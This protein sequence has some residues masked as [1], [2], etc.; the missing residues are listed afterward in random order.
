MGRVQT[1]VKK[2]RVDTSRKHT[3]GRSSSVLHPLTAEHLSTSSDS[4]PQREL[5]PAQP[6]TT[7]TPKTGHSSAKFA[8]LHAL[9]TG[10]ARCG[11]CEWRL[12]H[13]G[14]CPGEIV[15]AEQVHWHAGTTYS[16]RC[17]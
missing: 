5:F 15:R 9:A 2:R 13:A 12:I 16:E 7:E 4:I 3:P 17:S 6:A 10:R 8:S 11:G 14:L 1:T